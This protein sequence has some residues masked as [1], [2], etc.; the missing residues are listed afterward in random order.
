MFQNANGMLHD[1]YLL[2]EFLA[3]HIALINETNLQLTKKWSLPSYTVYRTE[4]HRPP[5]EQL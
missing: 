2:P 1:Q 3:E 4:G 5:H